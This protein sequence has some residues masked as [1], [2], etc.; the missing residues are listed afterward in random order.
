MGVARGKERVGEH[1]GSKMKE[2]RLMGRRG[3][4]RR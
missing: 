4:R 1:G 2:M 3:G